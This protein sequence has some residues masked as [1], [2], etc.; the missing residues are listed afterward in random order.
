M[1]ADKLFSMNQNT[2]VIGLQKNGAHNRNSHENV[3]EEEGYRAKSMTEA[4]QFRQ[5]PLVTAEPLQSA[6]ETFQYQ[7]VQGGVENLP[8]LL[9]SKVSRD[10]GSS[11]G[12]Q[13]ASLQSCRIQ[14]Y[15]YLHSIHARPSKQ[16]VALP[17]FGQDTAGGGSDPANS[18]MSQDKGSPKRLKKFSPRW[19]VASG[20]QEQPNEAS[21]NHESF[22][23]Q[24]AGTIQSQLY[25][26]RDMH[27]FIKK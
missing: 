12:I 24:E 8:V 6:Q 18:T 3:P 25:F 16:K 21:E 7:Q 22:D 17:F 15:S 4:S 13:A 2:E 5:P 19:L 9:C 20:I 14:D 26:R 11:D 27:K 10:L 23:R 1:M